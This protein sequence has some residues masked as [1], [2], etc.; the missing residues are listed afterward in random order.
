MMPNVTTQRLFLIECRIALTNFSVNCVAV[1][2]GS[3]LVTFEGQKDHLNNARE[4]IEL[5][6]LNTKTFETL[7]IQGE[8]L[9]CQEYYLC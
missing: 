5:Y 3:I 2:S 7:Q 9:F 6:G 1:A 8:I 4:D